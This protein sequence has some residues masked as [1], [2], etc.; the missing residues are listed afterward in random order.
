MEDE[1]RECPN[2]GTVLEEGEPECPSCGESFIDEDE[3]L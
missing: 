1:Q 3:V 2:C